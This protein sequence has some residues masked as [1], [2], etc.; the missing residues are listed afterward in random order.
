VL[1]LTDIE[2]QIRWYSPERFRELYPRDNWWLFGRVGMR[3]QRPLPTN[4]VGEWPPFWVNPHIYGNI[5]GFSL[6]LGAVLSKSRGGG[7]R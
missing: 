3:L 5:L 7:P 4:L 6:G 1:W 2:L